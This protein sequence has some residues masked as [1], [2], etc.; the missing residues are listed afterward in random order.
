MRLSAVGYFGGIAESP[1]HSHGPTWEHDMQHEPTQSLL[2]TRQEAQKTEIRFI[3]LKEVLAICGKSRSSVY[4][5]IQKGKFP[6]PVKLNGRSS[7]WVRSEVEQWAQACI[8]ARETDAAHSSH[9]R[10]ACTALQPTRSTQ[11]TS[12]SLLRAKLARLGNNDGPEPV[13]FHG[14]PVPP[15][16]KRPLRSCRTARSPSATRKK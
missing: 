12:H 9:G 7:A 13:V 1:L 11:R 8:D 10:P 2:D 15:A 16:S 3:R 6:R 4:D 5:A 14:T